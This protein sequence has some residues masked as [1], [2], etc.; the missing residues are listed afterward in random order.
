MLYPFFPTDCADGS[1]ERNECFKN[2]Q[3]DNTEGCTKH[4]C[5]QNGKCHMLPEGP[6]CVCPNGFKLSE[7]K[8]EC[9]VK[10]EQMD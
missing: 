2:N 8:Q 5:G 7:N 9:E 4:A 6:T 3:K 1:D 10:I